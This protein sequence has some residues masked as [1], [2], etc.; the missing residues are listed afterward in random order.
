MD[1]IVVNVADMLFEAAFRM[2]REP[3]SAEYKAGVLAALQDRVNRANHSPDR[4]DPP[5]PMGTALCDAWLAGYQEGMLVWE[6]Q[7][8]TTL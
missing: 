2:P 5:Y 6:S 4:H 1:T 8:E 3:R 7:W